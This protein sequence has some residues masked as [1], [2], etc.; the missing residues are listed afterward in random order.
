M[1]EKL[2]ILD[3]EEEM[4]DGRIAMLSA[5]DYRLINEVILGV[6]KEVYIEE[7]DL[8][9]WLDPWGVQTYLMEKWRVEFAGSAAKINVSAG[10][11]GTVD[12]R[13][14]ARPPSV[15]TLN[16]LYTAAKS[17]QLNFHRRMIQQLNPMSPLISR[18]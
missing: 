16:L 13:L 3:I 9:D 1:V 5:V 6:V 17:S 12:P 2:R 18:P 8:R 11:L 10:G 15:S 4:S 14:L 7:G